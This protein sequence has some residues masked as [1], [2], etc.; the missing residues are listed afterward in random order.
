[1]LN[2]RIAKITDDKGELPAYAWPGGYP[3]FYLNNHNDVLCPNCANNH[4]DFDETIVAY[5]V[6]W[7][8]ATLYCDHCNEYIDPAYLDGKELEAARFGTVEA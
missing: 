4:E 5:D 1:M 7:E 8:D 6:N 3:L 2:S